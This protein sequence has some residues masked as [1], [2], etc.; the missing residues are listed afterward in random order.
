MKNLAQALAII[1]GGKQYEFEDGENGTSL[2]V[3][4]DYWSGEQL[5]LDLSRLTDEM[6]DELQVCDPEADDEDI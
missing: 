1:S 6:L 5:R 4:T 2:L 3:I